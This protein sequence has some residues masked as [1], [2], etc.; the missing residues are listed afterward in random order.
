MAEEGK[1]AAPQDQASP[2]K[3]SD[4]GKK[5]DQV[6]IEELDCCFTATV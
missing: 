3:K 1:A 4:N 5:K 2:A 6:P